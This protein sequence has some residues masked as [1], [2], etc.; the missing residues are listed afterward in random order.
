MDDSAAINRLYNSY[1]SRRYPE[2]KVGNP[3]QMLAKASAMAGF[4]RWEKPLGKT[5]TFKGWSIDDPDVPGQQLHSD[6]K[7]NDPLRPSWDHHPIPA[8]HIRKA[9]H[10]LGVNDPDT[11][12]ALYK[13]QD[14]LRI[15][16]KKANNERPNS[17]F[18]GAAKAAA[19]R[20]VRRN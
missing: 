20:F 9:A 11:W 18:V 3:A 1:L 19:M 6:A 12:R 10:L 8:E 14:N 5:K 15:Q 7:D 2:G 13:A 4:Q 16:S 17:D